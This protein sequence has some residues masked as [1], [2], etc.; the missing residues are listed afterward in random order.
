MSSPTTDF[1]TYG[2]VEEACPSPD[3]I[4]NA[5]QNK[6]PR[7]SLQKPIKLTSNNEKTTGFTIP[8]LG[9]KSAEEGANG[10]EMEDGWKATRWQ[11]MGAGAR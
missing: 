9:L 1:I 4:M 8:N 11:T 10:E 5:L 7:R 3:A 2:E 6:N